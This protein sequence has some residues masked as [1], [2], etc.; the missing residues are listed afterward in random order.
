MNIEVINPKRSIRNG[1]INQFIKPISKA[2]IYIEVSGFVESITELEKQKTNYYLMYAGSI[3]YDAYEV[4]KW[5]E[6]SNIYSKEERKL[7]DFLDKAKSFPEAIKRTLSRLENT[8]ILLTSIYS[9]YNYPLSEKINMKNN[10][11]NVKTNDVILGADKLRYFDDMHFDSKHFIFSKNYNEHEY[12][13]LFNALDYEYYNGNMG[14]EEPIDAFINIINGLYSYNYPNYRKVIMDMCIEFL[15]QR[16]VIGD[17]DKSDVYEDYL[18]LLIKHSDNKHLIQILR[19]QKC[20]M[21]TL[22]YSYESY[23]YYDDNMRKQLDTDE[24]GVKTK[25]VLNKLRRGKNIAE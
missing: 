25:G 4:L 21:E 1:T 13:S 23:D 17:I 12:V 9:A 20:M 24:V 7:L 10:I 14:D 18:M 19:D 11:H 16:D 15:F 5:K 8:T 6:T 2:Q 22:A 3:L